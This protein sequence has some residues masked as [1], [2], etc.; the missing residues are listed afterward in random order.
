MSHSKM[1]SRKRHI[2]SDEHRPDYHPRPG[3]V[4]IARDAKLRVNITEP[5]E[6]VIDVKKARVHALRRVV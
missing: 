6:L 3:E 2:D 5:R 1:R 4:P